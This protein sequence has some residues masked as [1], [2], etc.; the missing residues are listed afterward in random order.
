MLKKDIFFS[1][2][3]AIILFSCLQW[4]DTESDA[5]HYTKREWKEPLIH[6]QKLYIIKSFT[7]QISML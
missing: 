2:K 6:S 4:S 7:N 1:L 3:K 5:N